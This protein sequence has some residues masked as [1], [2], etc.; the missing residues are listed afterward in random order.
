MA[1]QPTAGIDGD[2]AAY[3]GLDTHFAG[4]DGVATIIR[5]DC[6]LRS[7]PAAPGR[8]T[9]SSSPQPAARCSASSR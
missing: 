3:E 2:E 5:P 7:K 9:S 1:A 6:A 8:T 4:W